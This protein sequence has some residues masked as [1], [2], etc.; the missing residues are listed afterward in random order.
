MVSVLL[1]FT[2]AP[3]PQTG[4]DVVAIAGIVGT[5]LGTLGGALIGAFVTS[6]VQQ[7]QLAHEDETR[8]HARRLAVYAEFRDACGKVAAAIATG[9]PYLSDNARAIVSFETLRLVATAP[10]VEA[11]TLVSGI[12]LQLTQAP[13]PQALMPQYNINMALLGNAMR[14]ELGV[15]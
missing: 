15:Q 1:H 13:N 7:R 10:V 11:A 3:V 12:V 5:L 6:R 8:F 4:A 14:Q 9:Q 2:Q